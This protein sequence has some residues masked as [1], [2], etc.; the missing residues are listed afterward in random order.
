MGRQRFCDGA[1]DAARQAVADCLTGA[2]SL[3]D[4]LTPQDCQMLRYQ[5]LL[6]IKIGGQAANALISLNQAADDHETMSSETRWRPMLD[7]PYP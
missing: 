2:P 4:A 6:Q 1:S 3:H 7:L 5:R